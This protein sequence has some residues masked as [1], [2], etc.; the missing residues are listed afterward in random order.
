MGRCYIDQSLRRQGLGS[1]LLQAAEGY[2][3][4]QQFRCM[5]LHTH[6]F[7]PGGFQFWQKHG[8][9]ITLDEGGSDQIVH[10]E[11]FLD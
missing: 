6:C 5:Y 9:Q 4:E 11:K 1:K 2:C 7:L 10:M 3:R 8:F